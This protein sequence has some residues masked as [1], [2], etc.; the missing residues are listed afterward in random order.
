MMDGDED[1]AS[2][3][4]PRDATMSGRGCLSGVRFAV[5]A[6]A[7][8]AR[9]PIVTTPPPTPPA[10]PALPPAKRSPWDG[11]PVRVMTW[12]PHGVQQIGVLPGELPQ[13]MPA[14]W[15]V[16]PIARLDQAALGPLVE[17]ID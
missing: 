7:A 1:T 13:P 12:T 16:E 15:Y 10:V 11:M 17:V 14:R 4:G 3:I 8:C 5:L 9:P 2:E 6:I